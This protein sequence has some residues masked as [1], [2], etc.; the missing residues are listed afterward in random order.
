MADEIG[1]LLK[2]LGG[3]ATRRLLASSQHQEL[4]SLNTTERNTGREPKGFSRYKR[5]S[6]LLPTHVLSSFVRRVKSRAH[7]NG[8]LYS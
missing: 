1:P 4:T 8:S 6:R 2:K 3:G 7:Y 5:S